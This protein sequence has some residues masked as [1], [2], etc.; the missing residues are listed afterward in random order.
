MTTGRINQVAFLN[1][2]ARR[3]SPPRPYGHGG[4]K[5]SAAVV[6]KEHSFWAD[7]SR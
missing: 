1:D 5:A 2:A 3:M 6:R 4:F 7:R